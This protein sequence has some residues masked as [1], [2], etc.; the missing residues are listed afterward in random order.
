MS[1]EE[2]WEQDHHP[3]EP[4]KN[5]NLYCYSCIHLIEDKTCSCREYSTKPVSVLKGGVCYEYIRHKDK[6]LSKELAEKLDLAIMYSKDYTP[7]M[8]DIIAKKSNVIHS[9]CSDCINNTGFHDCRIFDKKPY[10]YSSALAK[11]PCPNRIISL[12]SRIKGALY[13]FA[14][15]D[16]MGA[17]TEFMTHSDIKRKYDIVKDIIGG[18]WLNLK[19]GEVTDDTQMTLC[20]CK[21]LEETIDLQDVSMTHNVNFYDRC[22]K[23]FVEWFDT[24]P[25][26]IGNCCRNVISTCRKYDFKEWVH[27]ANNPNSLGNGSLMRSMPLVLANQTIETALTQGRL[28]HNNKKCDDCIEEYCLLL[29]QCIVGE[30]DKISL[31]LKLKE[32]TG[33]VENTL[34]NAMYWLFETESVEEAIIGAVNHGGDADTIAAITGSLVGAYYGFNAIPSRWIYQLSSEVKELL[35]HY[36]QFFVCIQQIA[37]DRSSTEMAI[38][39][40]FKKKIEILQKQINQKKP[41]INNEENTKQALINPFLLLL[42]YDVHNPNEVEFEFNASFSY[43]NSDKVD[44]AIKS[45]G[46][47]IF[48]V[49]AKKITEDLSNHYAQL[50]Y[51]LS[52]NSDVKIGILT[53]G[54]NYKFF[55]YF[56]K[57]K[58]MDKEPFFEVDIE[59]IN[60]EQIDILELFCKEELDLNKLIKKGEELWYDKKITQ[61]LRELLKNPN[62]D[63]I[64]LLAKDYCPTKITANALEKFRPI[65]NNA[66]TTAITDITQ[67]TIVEESIEEKAKTIITTDEELKAFDMVKAIL[68]KAGKDISDIKHKDTK[69]YFAIYK[70]NI[71][72]W[73]VRFILDLQPT[74]AMLNIEYTLVKDIPT[75]LKIQPLT[76]KGITKVFIDSVDDIKNLEQFI[77][78]AFER[79]E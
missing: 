66:I 67:E 2:K 36:T 14:I 21:A 34:D 11:V 32:P 62:D 40:D 5:E 18:G 23:Y 60:G 77:L 28:T 15:G 10:Q 52:T 57:K 16:A 74:L 39:T 13:G 35:D 69:S 4:V 53:N 64:R 44:Y 22:C 12:E 72:G 54:I 3:L 9:Q 79:V 55:G 70:R 76:S 48:F 30:L 29:K 78:K 8:L 31:N 20:V 71:N 26:D 42:G 1:L 33:H 63:F 61:K 50:E 75:K 7:E 6:E 38:E 27:F 56:E 68:T 41:L 25:V 24:K 47:P 51:Y 49:E 58:T 43:K 45:N 37:N 73:F 65:V 46:K 17:T 59:N 19:E